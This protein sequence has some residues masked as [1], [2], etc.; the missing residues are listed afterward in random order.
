IRSVYSPR[1]TVDDVHAGSW[2]GY[3]EALDAGITT[4]VDHSHAMRSPE[5]ADAVLDAMQASR[6]RG[7]LAYGLTAV[8]EDGENPVRVQVESTWRHDDV[9]RLRRDRLAA[10]DARVHLG[11]G[12]CDVS[13]FLPLELVRRELDLGRELGLRRI[14]AHVAVGPATQRTRLVRRLHRAGL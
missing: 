4:V 5:H 8:P 2:A 11:I 13:E 9:R 1:Y 7:V 10:D 14:T 12:A 3:L 6:I